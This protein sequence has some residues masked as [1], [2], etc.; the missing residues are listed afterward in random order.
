[1]SKM[2]TISRVVIID[3][4][5]LYSYTH[6]KELR[7]LDKSLKVIFTVLKASWTNI[8]SFFVR[9]PFTRSRNTWTS[10]LNLFQTFKQYRIEAC[11]EI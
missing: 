6:Y 5:S 10:H 11:V 9:Y 3:D 1:M 8:H 7:D 4:Q 2:K